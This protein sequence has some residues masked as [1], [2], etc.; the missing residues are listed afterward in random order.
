MSLTCV[1]YS[2]CGVERTCWAV[3]SWRCRL[4]LN[5]LSSIPAWSTTIYRFLCGLYAFPCAR[6]SEV[7]QETLITGIKGWCLRS[8]SNGDM[9]SAAPHVQH[10][11]ASFGKNNLVNEKIHAS[12]L[13]DR[14]DK[15]NFT[16][17][18]ASLSCLDMRNRIYKVLPNEIKRY[19]T[20]IRNKLNNLFTCQ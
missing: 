19:S 1:F 13:M 12:I 20:E 15:I 14:N 7:N 5:I 3:G 9:W 6:A 11:L 17:V 4:S 10:V 16:R 18:K 8:R 2:L